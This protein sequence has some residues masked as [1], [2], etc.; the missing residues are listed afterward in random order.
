[1]KSA[2]L[3]IALAASAVGVSGCNPPDTHSGP[4]D[5]AA[6]GSAAAT[7][8]PPET[9]LTVPAGLHASV[10]ANVEGAR[11][12]TVGPDGA[13]YV[14]Q[15]AS[16]QITRLAP[17]A[18]GV[19]GPATVVLKGLNKP[20]GMAFH[21]GWFYVANTD[22]VVRVKLDA[23]GNAV[24]TPE[25]V[26]H[27]AA[28]P[29]HWTRSITF[30]PDNRMY[31]SIGSSCN[32]CVET[33][34]TRAAVMQYDENGKNGRVFAH[35]L[36][37]AVGIAF[38]PVTHELWAS[39]NERDNITP[40]HQDLP[41]EELNIVSDG[42]DYGWPYCYADRV[43]NPE[44]HDAA[45]CAGTIAPAL[46]MQAHSA[47]LSLTFLQDATQLP[48][49]DRGDALIAFHGSWDRDTPTGAKVVRVRIEN[50]K[51]VGYDDFITGWQ[52]PDGKRWGRPVDV[53]V[54]KD[55]SLLVSDDQSGEITRISR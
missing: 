52:A 32:V 16:D 20:H 35:G 19:A 28:G 29:M 37:N 4:G 38:N 50:N 53:V 39:Q 31:V 9:R 8:A 30:G 55:G 18:D 41:P 11:Y 46:Q 22:G 43:P 51:P 23:S 24:G 34:S 44:F 6:A 21:D 47:P 14:S 15:P 12:M 45:R 2:F 13:V 54:M 25:Q 10:Y 40:D 49:A 27:Y 48:D 36:R 17:G 7:T 42:G 5:S 26:N 33:D 1:M 3:L